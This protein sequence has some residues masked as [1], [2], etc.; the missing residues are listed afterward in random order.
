MPVTVVVGAQWG[1]EGKG[2]IVDILSSDMDYVVRYQGGANAG[3]T[4][5]L[6]T[7][8]YILH[9]VPSGILHPGS[10][11]I[12]GNG[13]VVDPAALIEEINFLQGKNIKVDNRLFISDRAHLI[14]S[15]HKMLDKARE[16]QVGELRIGT[17]GR[18]IGP[19]YVDKV[20]RCGIRMTDIMDEN[21]LRKKITARAESANVTLQKIYHQE[22]LKIQQMVEEAM[23][24]A[25][26]IRPFITDTTVMINKAIDDDKKILLEGAQGTLLDVDHGTYPFVT[27]S[28]PVSA[29]ACIGSGI[30]PTRIDRITGVMKAYTTRVGEGPFP[31]ELT[32]TEGDELR[33]IGSEYG[34]TTG[35]P[36]RCGWFDLVIA[37]YS[38]R[39]NGLTSLALT[40][41]DILDRFDEIKVC[42]TYE[43]KGK[44]VKNFPADLNIL[45]KCVPIYLTLPGWKTS[46]SDI[47]SYDDLPENA[48]KYIEFLEN[49]IGVHAEMISV[50]PM[51]KRIIIR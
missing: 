21:L 24:A 18:G 30:G 23:E 44:T 12:I 9:L 32:G 27:S 46:T 28:N 36:R 50:G 47:T 42:T 17:T 22:P 19:A 45:Q 14:F 49:Q 2:K 11:C 10:V 20:N 3:H 1:D 13:V 51:R 4:I 40:K 34:A 5:E 38:A 43:Y 29:G 35:R 25:I 8:Q 48:R 39:V 31:T 37:R 33:Q 41:L 16:D 7:E 6:G 26:I 15:F